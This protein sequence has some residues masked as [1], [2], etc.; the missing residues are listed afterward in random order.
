M[1]KSIDRDPPSQIRALRR[2]NRFYAKAIDSMEGQLLK[3]FSEAEMHILYELAYKP[4]STAKQL[5][6]T[7]SMDPGYLSRTLA[8]MVKRK[9]ITRSP[10]ETD[11][12]HQPI[13]LTKQG[14]ATFKKL[15]ALANERIGAVL[16]QLTPARR[17]R[18]VSAMQQVTKVMDSRGEASPPFI[19][20][21]P[22]PGDLGWI[23]YRHGTVIA[24]E[25]GWD[26]HFEGLIAEIVGEFVKNYD[27]TS[28]RGIIAE[29][30]GEIAG[31]VFLVRADAT[32][33]KLRVLYVEPHMRGH[34]L[35]RKLVEKAVREAKKIGYAKVTL[36][37]TRGLDSARKIYENAGFRLVDETPNTEFSS[38][39]LEPVGQ[40]WELDLTAQNV[41][42]YS[43]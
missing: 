4:Q 18:L 8:S 28:D 20:R 38:T 33:A 42:G 35:G 6:A 43:A 19:F 12:R 17:R 36:W 10:S 21:P 40:H 29:H 7:L 34:G 41:E 3:G 2:F 31:S 16:K 24:E 5:A 39:R 25:F 22:K 30:D 11:A 15:D 9:L 37:T 27:A 14:I 23:V 26:E 1:T 13:S 32:S